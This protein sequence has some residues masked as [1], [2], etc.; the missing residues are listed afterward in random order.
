MATYILL[1]HK[2]MQFDQ[3]TQSTDC[4]WRSASCHTWI[5]FRFPTEMHGFTTSWFNAIGMRLYTYSTTCACTPY[6]AKLLN[7][8][9]TLWNIESLVTLCQTHLSHTFMTLDCCKSFCYAVSLSCNKCWLHLPFLQ[10][11]FTT[12]ITQ[13]TPISI[14]AT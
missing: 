7:P 10:T 5:V 8:N 11:T 1:S 4:D 13:S 6:L 12:C 3:L 14:L 9:Q 2:L